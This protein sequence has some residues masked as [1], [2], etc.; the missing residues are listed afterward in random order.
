MYFHSSYTSIFGK[1]NLISTED[2]LVACYFEKQKEN[3]EKRFYPF[4]ESDDLEII[5][6]AKNWLDRYFNLEKPDINELDLL[7][8]GTDF[9][10]LIWNYL[11]EIPFG[12]VVT[13]KELALKAA[14]DRNIKKMSARAVG[15]ALNKNP[16]AI[17][18]PCHRVIGSNFQLIGYYGGISL[19]KE[20]LEFEGVYLNK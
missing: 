20:L 8:I 4:F 12:E 10:K 18:L 5:K 17:I 9:Q 7:L 2:K 3:V 6:R 15:N 11:K 16:I 1:I 13:Y 14:Y 19:K